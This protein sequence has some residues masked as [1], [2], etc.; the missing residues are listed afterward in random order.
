MNQSEG[1]SSMEAAMAKP[2]DV[3]AERERLEAAGVEYVFSC[4]VDLLGQPKTKPVPIS[5]FDDLFAGKGPQFA[6]HSVSMTPDLGPA[7]PDQIALADLDSVRICPWDTRYAWVMADLYWKGEPY[8]MCP[9]QAL[10]RQVKA[11]A[12]LGYAF[13]AGFEPE[14]IVLRWEDGKAVKAF[15]GL[16]EYQIGESSVRRQSFGYDVEHTLDGMAFLDEV[17]RAINQLGWGLSNVVAEGAYS[18]FELDFGPSDALDTAD[19][20]VL[21]RVL[22]KEI[23]KRHGLFVTYMAKPSGGDWR[24]GAHINHSMTKVDDPTANLFGDSDG[25][26]SPMAFN[27]LAGVLRHGAA[28]TSIAC[29]TVNSYK[30]LVGRAADLEGGTLTW[31]PTHICYGFNNRSAMVRLPQTRKAI[32]NRACDMCVNPHMAMALTMAASLEGVRD[33]LQPGD[34]IDVPLY[35]M[36]A[37]E[38]ATRSIERL[39]RNLF[40]AATAL[41]KDQLALE[42]FGP[43][44]HALAVKGK[45]DE[46]YRFSE[47]VTEWEQAEYLQFF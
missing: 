42:V 15:G 10:K 30:G 17:V 6:T 16:D 22:L 8:N 31:A 46:W 28:I 14:F 45:F 12:E 2:A 47:H 24:N 19:R 35:D 7:D 21:L 43:T 37:E 39:P 18:Q 41:E 36:S 40:E 13:T 29:P 32:E 34:P 26:W 1:T 3:A 9:R 44:M 23:A 4:W 20:L 38:V 5:E 25:G 33:N 11:A 27:A